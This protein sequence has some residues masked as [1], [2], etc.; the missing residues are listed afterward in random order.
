LLPSKHV[1]CDNA[2][3]FAIDP[4]D[5]PYRGRAEGREGWRLCG[6]LSPR[7]VSS[8]FRAPISK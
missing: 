7:F 5:L 2:P 8:M 4:V 6:P 3:S 1:V